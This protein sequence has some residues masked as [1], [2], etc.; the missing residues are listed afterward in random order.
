MFLSCPARKG[1]DMKHRKLKEK[2]GETPPR[3][4]RWLLS[5]LLGSEEREYIL[6]DFNEMF[7]EM[8]GR[9]G[10]SRAR[11][12]YWGQVCRSFRHFADNLIYWRIEM[13]KNYF[14]LSFRHMKKHKGYSFINIFGL[15]VGIACCI[16]I[17]LW[18]RDELSYDKFHE[19]GENIHLITISGERGTWSSSP[20]AL[21]PVLKKD[22]PEIEK[23]SWYGVVQLLTKHGENSFFEDAALVG[24]DFLEMFTFPFLKGDAATALDDPASVVL[25]ESTAR[26][27]FGSRDPMGETIQFEN[28]IDLMVTGV[29]KDVPRNSHMAFDL[30]A[31]PAVYFGEERMKTWSMDVPAYVQLSPQADAASVSAK[32]AG[33]V[34]DHNKSHTIR[35]YAG[36]FPMTRMHLYALNGT[37]PIV[38]VYVF[39]AIAVV[40]LL[41]ACIN[42]MNLATA[43]A[44]IRVNEI[45]IRKV[46][47]GVRRDL[48]KQFLGESMGMALMALLIAV[49]LVYA[50]LPA[51][52][53]LAG[54]EMDFGL[55]GSG[56]LI[57]GLIGFALLTGFVAGSYPAFYFSSFQPQRVLKNSSRTGSSRS[58]LRKVLIVFQFS[59]S[60][61]L[62]I[63]VATILRQIDYIR[64]KD[65]GFDRE[66]IVVVQTRREH[67]ARYST[68]KQKF[69]EETGVLNVTAASSIPLLINNNNPVYWEGRGPDSYFSMNFACV[70]YDYFETF[71]MK[72]AYGRSFSR[73]FPT[74]RENY[75]I[76][77]SALRLTGYENP[78]GRMFSM[79]DKEGSLVGVVKDF[80]G[81]SLHSD[82]RPVVFV[83]YQNMPYRYWFIKV[84][85][86]F[87]PQSLDF[88]KSTVASV[89]P[90]YPVE[91]RFLD[92]HFQEQYLREGRLGRILQNFTLLAVFVSCLG[93][94]GLAAFMASRRSKE[95]AIRKVLGASNGCIMGI[96]NREF[97]VLVG[98]SVLIS[99]PLGFFV[100]KK[101]MANFAYHAKLGIGIFMLAA[102][103]AFIVAFLTVSF[104]SFRA[105]SAN[106]ADH[107]R[108]E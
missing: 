3:F 28:R 70:D 68:I 103:I 72:M 5:R 47:G 25:T 91:P 36:L 62:I 37:D 52:N 69:L 93:L 74:D 27:Y 82:I 67:R 23:V 86:A 35:Y 30:L 34:N 19:N 61:L 4:A 64:T 48:I 100:M 87:V 71:G 46:L 53:R 83:M 50:V 49:G 94:F 107:L 38:Y 10:F 78:I 106:P 6:G 16:L 51:F 104:Q 102:A 31:S 85:G 63:A 98:L 40:V 57:A 11:L 32:I 81:T 42:F 20:W 90:S 18:V 84:S 89:V 12:W 14:L 76:N 75:I 45:G 54:K 99:W 66:R 22:F 43:R 80:H 1:F 13:F 44:S 33:V 60:V 97:A 58:G 41:I 79:W 7:A 88:I 105:A 9:F 65:L 108:N 17:F 24:P 2:S 26:K 8:A 56:S 73:E 15:A 55:L 77:E 96:L 92:E 59:A 95:I 21:P 29:I 39:S 101:W